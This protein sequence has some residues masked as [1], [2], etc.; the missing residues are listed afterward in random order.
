ME[1]YSN[2]NSF[3]NNH[4]TKYEMK[5]PGADFTGTNFREILFIKWNKMNGIKTKDFSNNGGRG[6]GKLWRT[7][8]WKGNK[9]KFRKPF[10][11]I[12]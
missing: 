1:N 3:Y 10:N 12:H 6:E 9:W 11:I 5:Y 4:L 2:F 8:V 7:C